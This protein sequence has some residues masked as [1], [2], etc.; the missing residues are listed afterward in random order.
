MLNLT[1][2]AVVVRSQDGSEHSFPPSGTV[3]RVATTETAI[4]TCPVTG[5]TIVVRQLGEPVGLPPEGTPCL[6]SAMVA[7]ACPG[8]N[9]VFAPDTGPTA[10]RDDRGLIVAVTRLVAA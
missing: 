9:G 3:A 8:R 6:V 7:S 10:V 4:G 5:A 2:H 1:P